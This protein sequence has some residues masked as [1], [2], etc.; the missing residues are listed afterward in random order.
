MRPQLNADEERKLLE[1]AQ[2]QVANA[3]GSS[4]AAA[5]IAPLL[6][7]AIKGQRD[8]PR[9]TDAQLV[10]QALNVA[11]H[12]HKRSGT[13]RATVA[14]LARNSATFGPDILVRAR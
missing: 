8:V 11:R 6:V 13:L 7:H 5:D 3:S 4:G 10:V 9:A 12:N 14:A 1:F 2:A